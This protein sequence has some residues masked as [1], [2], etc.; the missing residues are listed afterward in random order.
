[1]N[2]FDAI[3]ARR[4]VKKFDPEHTMTE[5]EITQ[6]MNATILTPT[7]FNIQNWRFVVITDQSVKEQFKAIGWNQA[8]F[9]DCSAL[10]LVCGDQQAYGQDT[11]RYWA[12]T[13]EKTREI[14][15]GMIKGYYGADAGLC[16]DE[17]L[18]SGGMA[19]MTIM[20]AAQAMGYD[21]CPMSG[22]DFEKAAE[23]VKLPAQ[24]DII[25]SVAV[26]KGDEAA[27]PR[28]GQLPLEDVCFRDSF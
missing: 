12:S 1:M 4:S 22:F 7:A 21:S 3:A 5:A 25:M 13:D 10:V 6:L 23:I 24:H 11:E 20:L 2:T 18:K 15:V 8:Q 16:R 14:I 17:N 9:S 19:A 28:G 27:R 26:G